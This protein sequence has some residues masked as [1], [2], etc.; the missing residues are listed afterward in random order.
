LFS[1]FGFPNLVKCKN[2]D[3]NVCKLY[4]NKKGSQIFISETLDFAVGPTGL[5][6]VAS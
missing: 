3:E 6:P 5:E 2:K 4:A 1:L